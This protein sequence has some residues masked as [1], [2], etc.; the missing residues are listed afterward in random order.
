MPPEHMFN[1]HT[2]PIQRSNSTP[3]YLPK[4]HEKMYPIK[5][6]TCMPIVALFTKTNNWK[7]VSINKKIDINLCYIHLMEKQQ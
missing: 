7:Q 3:L 6:C 2:K 4:I 5:A 1:M